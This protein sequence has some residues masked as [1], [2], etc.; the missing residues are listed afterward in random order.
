MMAKLGA[1]SLAELVHLTWETK[2]LATQHFVRERAP[3]VFGGGPHEARCPADRYSVRYSAHAGDADARP[4]L[5][6]VG[7]RPTPRK[8]AGSRPQASTLECDTESVSQ[9]AGKQLESDSLCKLLVTRQF[10]LE[11]PLRPA[12]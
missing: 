1:R 5:I 9:N 10:G 7:R 11:R 6:R 4:V 12:R 2:T 3:A 8:S